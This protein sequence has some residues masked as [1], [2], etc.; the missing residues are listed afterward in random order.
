MCTKYV[1]WE[2]ARGEQLLINLQLSANSEFF[3]FICLQSMQ[4]FDEIY[5]PIY[6]SCGGKLERDGSDE[7]VNWNQPKYLSY[8]WPPTLAGSP[9]VVV[10]VD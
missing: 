6:S 4:Q 9:S 8:I 5:K 10:A 7:I 2:S 3:S 1:W